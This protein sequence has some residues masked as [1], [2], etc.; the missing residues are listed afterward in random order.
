MTEQNWNEAQ[1][2]KKFIDKLL[3][4]AGWKPIVLFQEG[5]SYKDASVEEYPLKI[6]LVE[7]LHAKTEERRRESNKFIS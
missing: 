1:T 7:W 5:K 4:D 6:N 2:R 3:V